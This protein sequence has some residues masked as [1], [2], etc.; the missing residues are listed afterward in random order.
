MQA[1][2]KLDQQIHQLAQTIAKFNRSYAPTKADDSHTNLAFDPVGSRLLGKWVES[3]RGPV[4]MALELPDFKFRIYNHSWQSLFSIEIDGKSQIQAELSIKSFLPQIGLDAQEF[5]DPMHF[6]I[7]K[8][9]FVNKPYSPWKEAELSSWENH[10]SL[11]NDASQWL[12]NHLQI[13]AETRIWPHHFDTGIYIEPT[14]S[15]GLGFGLAMQDSMIESPYYY[16]SGNG[17]NGSEIDYSS[18][19]N[20]R[21]GAWITNENWKGAI[22]KLPDANRQTVLEFIKEVTS[23]Y[24]AKTLKI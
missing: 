12:L 24:L 14:S 13:E 20:L 8:Y 23:W 4:I 11:A 18:A 3:G 10:R 9:E 15:V 5:M 22:L 17:L 16:L 7:T 21:Q 19:K 1:Y 6:E 2:N